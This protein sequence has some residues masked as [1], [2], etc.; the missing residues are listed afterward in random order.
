MMSPKNTQFFWRKRRLRKS[1]RVRNVFKLRP[2]FPSTRHALRE[3]R[4]PPILSKVELFSIRTTI[5]QPNTTQSCHNVECSRSSHFTV[6]VKMSRDSVHFG[7]DRQS[8]DATLLPMN[9]CKFRSTLRFLRFAGRLPSLI[10][11]RVS[12]TLPSQRIWD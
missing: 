2:N 7:F 12:V 11:E 1:L 6:V 10:E 4:S 3:P 9:T 8:P 5:P